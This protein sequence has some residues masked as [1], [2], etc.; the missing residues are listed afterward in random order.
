MK[1]QKTAWSGGKV[2]VGGQD[3]GIGLGPTDKVTPPAS[4]MLELLAQQ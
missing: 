4:D 3:G 2:V 1:G